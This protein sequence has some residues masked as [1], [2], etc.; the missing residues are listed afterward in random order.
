MRTCDFDTPI[1]D[2]RGTRLA[3]IGFIESCALT[4][5]SQR[6]PRTRV[7]LPHTG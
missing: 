3:F 7:L 2:P 1:I 5:A 4:S 6:H